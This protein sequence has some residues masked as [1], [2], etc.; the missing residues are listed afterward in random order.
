MVQPS[1]GDYGWPVTAMDRV[2]QE[3]QGHRMSLRCIVGWSI[4]RMAAESLII[5]PLFS[6][7]FQSYW[8]DTLLD[9]VDAELEMHFPLAIVGAL[10]S[11]RCYR[12]RGV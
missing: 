1:Y 4:L 9:E 3:T 6:A 11:G 12:G 2:F 5:K 7:C 8:E 10:P